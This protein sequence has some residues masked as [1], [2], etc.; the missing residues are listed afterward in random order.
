ALGA[1]AMLAG[2]QAAEQAAAD[3]GNPDVLAVQ[4]AAYK[5]WHEIHRMLGLLRFCPDEN[6]VYTAYCEPDHFILPALGPHFKDRFGKNAWAVIDK[7]R[8]LCL[9]CISGQNLEFS[10]CSENYS[11]ELPA[12]QG[13][14]EQ[15]WK[16]YHSAI[17]NETRANP[18]LQKSFMPKRYWKYLSEM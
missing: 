9:R 6:S 15:L 7:K 13:K 5:T 8:S 4:A 3:R 14:W 2:R 10:G 18:K 1:E 16:Q 17:N 11:V 12:S